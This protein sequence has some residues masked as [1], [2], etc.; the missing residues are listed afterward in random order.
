MVV[1]SHNT[2]ENFCRSITAR[3]AARLYLP[4]SPAGAG[5]SGKGFIGKAID[6]CIRMLVLVATV[7]LRPLTWVYEQANVTRTTGGRLVRKLINAGLVREHT[8]STGKRGG[9]LKILEVTYAGWVKLRELGI[10]Q[11]QDLTH[12][13]W[14]HNLIAAALELIGKQRNW[15]VSFEVVVGDVRMD[16]CWKNQQGKMVFFQ[17][18]TS[19][20][21]RE[22]TNVLKALKIP[23][24]RDNR[25]IL[26]CR[27]KHFA[28]QVKTLLK[29]KGLTNLLKG[30]LEL[31]FAGDVIQTVY[32]DKGADYDSIS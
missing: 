12:G 26:V 20:P 14:E 18:G 21:D 19:D 3:K 23:T 8:F 31:R 28:E 5:G 16:V 17:I 32:Q 22:V 30:T 9:K 15:Q 13:G 2:A 1:E 6:E 29:Q 11:P 10:Q 7:F 24:G 27:D 4:D 25:L